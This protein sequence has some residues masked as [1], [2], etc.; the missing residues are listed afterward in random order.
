MKAFISST[1]EITTT[2]TALTTTTIDFCSQNYCDEHAK[3]YNAQEGY[4]CVCDEGYFGNGKSCLKGNCADDRK[5]PENEQCVAPTSFQ[6]EC[7]AGFERNLN[8]KCVDIDECLTETHNCLFGHLCVNTSGSFTCKPKTTK[9]TNFCKKH[10][11]DKHADCHNGKHGYSCTCKEGYYGTGK[12]CLKGNCFKDRTC[13]ENE[14][15]T[16]ASSYECECSIGFERDLDLKCVDID[17]CSAKIHNCTAE[18]ICTNTDGGFVCEEKWILVLNTRKPSNVPI[19]IDPFGRRKSKEIGFTYGSGTQAR[20][21]CSLI[22]HGK[23]FLFGGFPNG[24]QISVVDG[25]QLVKKGNLSFLMNGG[26]CATRENE[27][28]ICFENWD[29]K[30]TW[31]N[32]HRSSGPLETFSKLAHSTH[33]HRQTRIAVTT[34]KQL[35]KFV[36]LLLSRVSYRCREP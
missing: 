15:C 7:S 22:W 10:D 11:C 6:C 4:T 31:R 29:D 9:T 33:N 8:Q 12:S 5:C 27:I 17:E 20:G 26:A 30:S 2:T 3:C 21:S 14:R 18:Q 32:C 1:P 34:G 19:V 25:C 35:F 24:R 28:F 36:L 16:S 23:M 13:P